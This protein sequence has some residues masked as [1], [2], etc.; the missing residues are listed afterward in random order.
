M[1]VDVGHQCEETVV[2]RHLSVSVCRKTG[3]TSKERGE[4]RRDPCH[5]VPHGL[6]RSRSGVFSRRP[7]CESVNQDFHKITA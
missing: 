3:V 6:I 4:E 2:G 1:C 7:Y 5:L